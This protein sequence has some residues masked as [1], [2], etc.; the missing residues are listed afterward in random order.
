MSRVTMGFHRMTAAGS[1][2]KALF[3]SALLSATA[4]SGCTGK[5][6]GPG[7][8]VPGSGAGQ[9]SGGAGTG[10]PSGSGGIGT[11][12][13]D[14][15]RVTMHRLNLAEYD[16]TMRDLLGTNA[17]PSAAF[18]F[19]PDDRGDDFDNTADVLTV[20]PLHLSCYDAAASSIVAAA[21]AAPAQRALL[22]SCELSA[23]GAACARTSLESFVP[24]AWRRPVTTAEIDRLMALVTSATS[25][26]DSTEAAFTLP[27]RPPLFPPY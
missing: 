15:G 18:N 7:E 9:T 16:N 23:G 10:R 2:A 8:P 5:I 11:A 6:G 27:V 19:P 26:G 4:T 3:W 22:V 24:R 20:S 21:M 13:T 1:W 14:P 25:Q 17:S 12:A